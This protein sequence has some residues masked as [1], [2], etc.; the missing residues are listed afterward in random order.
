MLLLW[1]SVK[2]GLQRFVTNC[3]VTTKSRDSEMSYT[4]ASL[5]PRQIERILKRFKAARL[6]VLTAFSVLPSRLKV[7]ILAARC[8]T[9]SNDQHNN[10]SNAATTPAIQ[11]QYIMLALKRRRQSFRH[12]ALSSLTQTDIITVTASPGIAQ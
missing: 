9:T 11:G 3:A 1:P 6:S 2:L 10:Q 8:R 5:M 7:S 4:S 12:S